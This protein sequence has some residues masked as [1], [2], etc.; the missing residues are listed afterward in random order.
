MWHWYIHQNQ[1]QRAHNVWNVP[2]YSVL[3]LKLFISPIFISIFYP[4][5]KQHNSSQY[6]GQGDIRFKKFF[7]FTATN[8]FRANSSNSMQERSW[9]IWLPVAF[10]SIRWYWP[11]LKSYISFHSS[12]SSNVHPL[13]LIDVSP[14]RKTIAMVISN[15]LC[16]QCQDGI[17]VAPDAPLTRLARTLINL[18]IIGI[19]LCTT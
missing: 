14:W 15:P 1:S 18:S 10:L 5:M 2:L 6:S 8:F 17:G 9:W 13:S 11:V 16:H 4:S 7:R 19:F 3:I 12:H